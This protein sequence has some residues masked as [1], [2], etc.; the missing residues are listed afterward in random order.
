MS[1]CR[2]FWTVGQ[3]IDYLR[4]EKELPDR[5]NQIYVV[6]PHF[7]LSGA[8]DLDQ[9]LRT[10]RTVKMET[11]KHETRHAIPVAMDQE[12]ARADHAAV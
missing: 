9:V 6:D 10:K 8:V 5:F 11:I 4:D 3:T 7:K 12:E 2:P 1:P